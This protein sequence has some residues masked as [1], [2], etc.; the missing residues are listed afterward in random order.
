MRGRPAERPFQ[1]YCSIV[2]RAKREQKAK[3]KAEAQKKRV[4]DRARHERAAFA[5]KL[6]AARDAAK[7]TPADGIVDDEE[8]PGASS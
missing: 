8:V 5:K 3:A 6:E 1:W 4:L 2:T 7:T